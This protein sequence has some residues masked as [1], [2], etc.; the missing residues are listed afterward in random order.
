M[1]PITRKKALLI[2]SREYSILVVAVIIS[3]GSAGCQTYGHLP[4]STEIPQSTANAPLVLK[5]GDEIDVRFR[6]WPEFDDVQV[7]RPDGKISL[8]LVQGVEA[9]GQ[10]PESLQA[11]LVELY[12]DKIRDPDIVV[13]VRGLVNH[14]I[15]VG[16]E[17]LNPGLF[18]MRG[19]MTALEAVMLAGGFDTISAHMKNV[20]IVRHIDGQRYAGAVD[21]KAALKDPESASFLLQQNDIVYVPRTVI[22]Q[23]NQFVDQYLNQM[24]PI[25][26]LAGMELVDELWPSAFGP[27]EAAVFDRDDRR[28]LPIDFGATPSVNGLLSGGLGR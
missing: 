5:P 17:V 6:Y 11:E 24:V 22:N 13:I 16:G 10:T 26:V 18:E 2:M 19:Q 21:L 23:A 25:Q 20:V 4:E 15:Y 28:T 12:K 9:A 8:Q 1:I 7:I 14:K 3:L 27:N